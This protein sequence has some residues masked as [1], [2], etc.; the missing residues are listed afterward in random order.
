M[1]AALERAHHDAVRVDKAARFP[2]HSFSSKV[3]AF[4]SRAPRRT[5]R[6]CLRTTAVRRTV[7]DRRDGREGEEMV[8]HTPVNIEKGLPGGETA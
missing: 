1:V 3:P 4:P 5:S 7:F 8:L 6:S 2:R